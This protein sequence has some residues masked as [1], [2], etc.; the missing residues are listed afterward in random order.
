MIFSLGGEIEKSILHLNYDL[1]PSLGSFP[2]TQTDCDAVHNK[3]FVYAS[4]YTEVNQL[5][6]NFNCFGRNRWDEMGMYDIPA[7]LNYILNV[8]GQ[9]KLTYVGHSMGNFAVII[10]HF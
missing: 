4:P 10:I 1:T 9:K 2:L 7:E 6:K 3:C 8:T 5:V